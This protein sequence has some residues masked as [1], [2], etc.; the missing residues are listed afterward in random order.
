MDFESDRRF[1]EALAL[2]CIMAAGALGVGVLYDDA[3]VSDAEI[4]PASGT[5]GTYDLTIAEDQTVD[6]IYSADSSSDDGGDDYS[7]IAL[8]ICMLVGLAVAVVGFLFGNRAVLAVGII[9]T[10]GSAGAFVLGIEL[11]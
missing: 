3:S 2:V 5:W 7:G 10:L 9:V 11:F 6:A 4:T 1:A 8:I